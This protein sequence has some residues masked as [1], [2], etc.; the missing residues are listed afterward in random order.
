M[1]ICIPYISTVIN[2]L[3][4]KLDDTVSCDEKV[5]FIRIRLMAAMIILMIEY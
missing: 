2:V 4:A 5:R 1:Y 3:H